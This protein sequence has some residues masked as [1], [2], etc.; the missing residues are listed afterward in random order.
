MS[1]R[2]RTKFTAGQDLCWT[3]APKSSYGPDDE[4]RV[5]FRKYGDPVM[6]DDIAEIFTCRGSRW[7]YL[8][9][10]VPWADRP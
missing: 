8:E 7:V 9:E 2:E 5:S 6:G 10:L 4:R 3:L 1:T